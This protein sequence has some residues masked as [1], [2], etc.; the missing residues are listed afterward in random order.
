M[1][2]KF[3]IGVLLYGDNPRLAERCLTSI[4]STVDKDHLNL[5]VGLNQVSDDVADWVKSWVPDDCIWESSEN[6]HKYPMM[7]QMVHGIKPVET[8]YFMWF[9]DDSYL[10]GYELSAPGK[11]YWLHL[12]EQSM[13]NAD[14]L[15]SVYTI[16]WQGQ[17]R[18]W[19]QAQ[20]W[21]NG[22]PVN[23]G[24]IKFITG[25]WWTIRT[26]WLYRWSYPWKALDHRGGDTMLGE[27]MRQQDARVCNFK[28]GVRVNADTLGREGAATRRGF[29]QPPCGAD[30]DP[31]VAATLHE[32]TGTPAIIQSPPVM[33]P[34]RIVE[35]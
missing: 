32:A 30:F 20:P 7:R 15:G 4:A 11:D 9:D 21:Y 29:D 25:G 10:T 31:G 24:R 17:Q 27:M 16:D 19:V 2:D 23:L 33:P 13:V 3:T 1:Q 5:R 22:Q 35:L 6:I 18:E 28:T 34:R 26:E 8:P 12:V 14:M